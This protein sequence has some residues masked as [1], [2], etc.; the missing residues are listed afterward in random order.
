M[1]YRICRA[2][3]YALSSRTTRQNSNAKVHVKKVYEEVSRQVTKAAK[4]T[5]SLTLYLVLP[6]GS[7]TQNEETLKPGH[8]ELTI[9]MYG[10]L[11]IKGH[12]T[13]IYVPA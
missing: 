12:Y 2:A 5:G 3:N 6:F 13:P 11:K 8:S 10:I 9:C 4:T 1:G 7:W